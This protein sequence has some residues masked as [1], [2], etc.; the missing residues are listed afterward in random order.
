MREEYIGRSLETGTEAV[1]LGFLLED[2]V[3]R[4]EGWQAVLERSL[5][6]GF[7]DASAKARRDLQVQ[8]RL[9]LSELAR[10]ADLNTHRQI[11]TL[12]GAAAGSGVF[13]M[14]SRRSFLRSAVGG[15]VVGGVAGHVTAEWT[16][17]SAEEKFEQVKNKAR[18][19]F[20]EVSLQLTND[21]SNIRDAGVRRLQK[22]ASDMPAGLD[23]ES[24]RYC[25]NKMVYDSIM[26][27]YSGSSDC[28]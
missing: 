9:N 14:I 28:K 7:L 11:S 19:S 25:V 27:A 20:E 8:G 5:R 16:F 12:T 24:F 21:A 2:I 26:S 1:S 15:G 6:K 4:T 22:Y 17:T 13:G 10:A 18:A 3:K 23:L